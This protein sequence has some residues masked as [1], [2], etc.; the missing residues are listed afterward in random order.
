M[1]RQRGGPWPRGDRNSPVQSCA[2][3]GSPGYGKEGERE[4]ERERE[5]EE[6]GKGKGCL[7]DTPYTTTRTLYSGHPHAPQHPFSQDPLSPVARPP[8]GMYTQ[9]PAQHQW[10]LQGPAKKLMLS[11]SFTP[12]FPPTAPTGSPC[13]LSAPQASLH[14]PAVGVPHW[15]QDWGALLCITRSRGNRMQNRN[16][17]HMPIQQVGERSGILTMFGAIASQIRS[18]AP[19]FVIAK[20]IL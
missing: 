6:K 19:K 7:N 2:A 12:S 10:C 17:L 16:I 1:D 8:T 20:P 11:I 13:P 5:G 18:G 14:L 15:E 3:T 4:R 9:T